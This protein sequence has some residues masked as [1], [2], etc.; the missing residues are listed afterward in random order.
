MPNKDEFIDALNS[1]L[2]AA[3][4]RGINSIDITSGDLHRKVGG[5]PGKNHNMPGCCDVMRKMMGPRDIVVSEPEKGK[6]ASL[7]IR[8]FIPR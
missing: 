1:E 3:I 8:Y 5:Y 7:V 6:G 4:N 2:R